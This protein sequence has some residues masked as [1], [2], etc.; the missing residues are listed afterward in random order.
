MFSVLAVTAIAASLCAVAVVAATGTL[1]RADRDESRERALHLAEAA[2]ARATT[3]LE[4]NPNYVSTTNTP[5]A[6]PSKAWVL[7]EAQR[8]PVERGTDGQYA[9]IVPPGGQVVYGVGY[10]PSRVAPQEVRVVRVALQ[11]SRPSGDLSFLSSGSTIVN[12][13]VDIAVG[14]SLH[15]NVDLSM[16]GSATIT[17]NATATGTFTR[18][19]GVVVNGVVGGGYLP[20]DIPTVQVRNYRVHTG[21]DL[22]PDGT[23]RTTTTT[24]P[25]TGTVVGSGLVGWRGWTFTGTEWRIE[26]SSAPTGG[27]YVYWANVR[28]SGNAG[29]WNSTVVVEGQR[30]LGNLVNGDFV[31]TGNTTVKPLQ[32]G[33]GVIAERD[34]I[35]AGNGTLHGLVV[36]GEQVELSGNASAIGQVISASRVSSPGSPVATSTLAGNVLIRAEVHAPAQRGGFASG[37][38]EEIS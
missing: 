37:G 12:G 13:N 17:G 8:A 25:C 19:P 3:A 9:W 18:G 20:Y 23:V 16:M 38:W 32:Q 2:A 36:A 35:V 31:M 21:H 6:R 10:V 11:R 5:P 15:A 33:V 34:I 26:G 27:F 28:I 24:L 29:L 1:R 22:C 30:V 7:E 14:G 4:A